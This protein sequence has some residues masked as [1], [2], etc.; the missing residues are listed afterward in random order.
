L[1]AVPTMG[2][3]RRRAMLFYRILA[4]FVVIFHFS[5]IAFVVFG[6]LAI[7]VGLGRGWGWVRN[8]WFRV[9]HLVAIVIVA[10]QALSGVICPLT[11]L[12]NALR[13]R[14]GQ[15]SYPGAFIGY[16]AHR[17]TFY[18]APTWAFALC[19]TLFGL[20]VLGTFALAPPRWQRRKRKASVESTG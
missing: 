11:M 16:W 19:Y 5:Y 14:A 1:Q 8:P 6:M 2:F 3:L 18:E 10:A 13:L 15:A 4:D 17:L 20:A 12:E 9:A 7:L